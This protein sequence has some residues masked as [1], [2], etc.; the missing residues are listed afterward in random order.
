MAL[1]PL[2]SCTGQAANRLQHLG[3]LTTAP[4]RSDS[5]WAFPDNK[6]K[7]PYDILFGDGDF[8]AFVTQMTGTATEPSLDFD[9]LPSFLV[10]SR[11]R[12]GQSGSPVIAYYPP[13]EPMR[14]AEGNVSVSG[15][16]VE[17]FL[18]VYSGRISPESDLRFVW[19]A[20]ALRQII[21]AAE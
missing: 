14:T 1:K 12:P 2:A 15:P 4:S 5:A 9:D 16:Q 7:H 17:R 3:C 11:T 6:V 19:K 20:K 21:E 10:D 8:T 13:G 18:G